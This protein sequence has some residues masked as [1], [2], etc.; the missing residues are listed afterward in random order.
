MGEGEETAWDIHGAGR[1]VGCLLARGRGLAC[2]LG[3]PQVARGAWAPGAHE[4]AG[5]R[6]AAWALKRAE[7]RERRR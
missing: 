4:K 2:A 1:P 7:R 3:R 5:R 6:S